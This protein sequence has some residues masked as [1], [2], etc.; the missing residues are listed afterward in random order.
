VDAGGSTLAELVGQLDSRYPG[1]RFRIIDEQDSI[2]QHI[3]I[4]VNQDLAA[5]LATPVTERDEVHI[6]CA[7]SGG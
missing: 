2:R 4:F 5:N 6:V 3:K 7:L 1:L